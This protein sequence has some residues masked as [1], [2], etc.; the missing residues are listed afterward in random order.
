MECQ[1]KYCCFTHAVSNPRHSAA[2]VLCLIR[3][4]GGA[5]GDGLPGCQSPYQ[6]VAQTH[7]WPFDQVIGG[8]RHSRQNQQCQ[9]QAGPILCGDADMQRVN[10]PICRY[11]QEDKRGVVKVDRIADSPVE[12]CDGVYEDAQRCDG[13]S[14]QK[15]AVQHALAGHT[16]ENCGDSSRDQR[17]ITEERHSH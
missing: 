7:P 2:S 9:K 14:R 17:I 12:A 13:Q 1:N 6:P 8:I 11:Q 3:L 10:D 5:A 4:T 16:P 15:N